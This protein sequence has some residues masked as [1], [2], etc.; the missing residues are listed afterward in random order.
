[1]TS[2]SRDGCPV[3]AQ[4]PS[5]A[6]GRGAGVAVTVSGASARFPRDVSDLPLLG[7]WRHKVTDLFLTSLVSRLSCERKNLGPVRAVTGAAVEPSC[8]EGSAFRAG[9][10][11]RQAVPCGV[12]MTL[13]ASKWAGFG[14]RG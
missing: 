2:R 10:G 7:I 5:R 1:M 14:G 11:G 12:S 4:G 8:G 6:S 3:P 9:R 13:G